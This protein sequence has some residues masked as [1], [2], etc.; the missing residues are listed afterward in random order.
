MQ[1]VLH[2]F[3][4]PDDR[5]ERQSEIAPHDESRAALKQAGSVVSNYADQEFPLALGE[6]TARSASLTSSVNVVRRIVVARL[7]R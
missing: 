4:L 6:A 2:D 7:R 1:G 5:N 3:V